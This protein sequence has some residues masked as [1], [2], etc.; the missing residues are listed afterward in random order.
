MQPFKL[1]SSCNQR[2]I[3]VSDLHHNE[4]DTLFFIVQLHAGHLVH[5]QAHVQQIYRWV[6]SW[7]TGE[8]M[9]TKYWLISYEV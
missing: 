9:Y 5:I 3:S 1:P 4:A 7:I 8:S 2:N 6:L